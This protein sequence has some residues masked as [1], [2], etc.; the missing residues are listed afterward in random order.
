MSDH[1]ALVR[2]PD[3]PGRGVYF[4]ANDTVYD[5]AVAFLNSLRSNS[6][7]LPLCWIPYDDRSQRIRELADRYD[8]IEFRN[9]DVLRRCDELSLQYHDDRC[10]AYRKLAMWSGPFEEFAYIDVDTVVVS[11]ISFAFDGLAH[12]DVLTSHSNI[13][14]IRKWVWKKSIYDSALLNTEQIAYAANT[15]FIVSTRS[16]ASFEQMTSGIE[17]GAAVKQHMTH[18]CKEQPALNYAIVTSGKRY[19]SISEMVKKRLLRPAWCELHGSVRGWR[20]QGGQILNR[21]PFSSRQAFLVHWA[22]FRNPQTFP[23]QALW[24]YY[25]DMDTPA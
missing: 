25:R 8:F 17:A 22:G 3:S 14:R 2:S 12:Y 16:F 15:G 24:Q 11:D 5:M 4:L 18:K 19:G 21:N 10:G 23:Y 13:A 1:K 9:N 6:R 7:H 20:V